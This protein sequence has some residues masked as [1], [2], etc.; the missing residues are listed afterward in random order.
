[1]KL[2]DKRVSKVLFGGRKGVTV[3]YTG[4]RPKGV[5]EKGSFTI[6][7]D[8]FDDLKNAAAKL[9]KHFLKVC[10]FNSVSLMT[11]SDQLTRKMNEKEI[12]AFEKSTLTAQCKNV[13]II[14]LTMSYDEDGK[15]VRTKLLGMYAN[16]KGESFSVNAPLVHL[17]REDYYGI[18]EELSRDILALLDEIKLF[19]NGHYAVFEEPEEEGTEQEEP[20]DEDEEKAEDTS[21]EMPFDEEPSSMK[22]VAKEKKKVKKAA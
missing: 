16:E 14:G 18:E 6:G 4:K 13:N 9:K 21:D 5:P 3:F 2:S 12:R 7:A 10:G 19:D 20:Q 15:L 1:M 17:D 8:P 11:N 22:V